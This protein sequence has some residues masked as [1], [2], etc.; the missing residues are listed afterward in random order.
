MIGWA[1]HETGIKAAWL[2]MTLEHHRA[3]ADDVIIAVPLVAFS[4]VTLARPAHPVV[5]FESEGG[6]VSSVEKGGVYVTHDGL[7]IPGEEL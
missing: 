4:L 2:S 5:E 7:K 1:N 6:S 3:F